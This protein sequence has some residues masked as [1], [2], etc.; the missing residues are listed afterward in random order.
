MLGGGAEG[1][2]LEEM[3]E[4]ERAHLA[5]FQALLPRYRA[6]PSLLLPLWSAAGYALGAASALAGREAAYA[7]TEA[8]EDVIS[9]HYNDQIRELRESGHADEAELRSVFAAFRDDELAHL[10]LAVRNGAH[11]APFY[12]ALSQTVKAGCRAA[13]Y[14]A[15][16]V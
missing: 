11:A 3:A 1:P 10:E 9:E 12:T 2:R 5:R 13:I 8:V 14:V 6:R 7:V 4:H 16:R 15:E